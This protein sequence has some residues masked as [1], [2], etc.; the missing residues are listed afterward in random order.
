MAFLQ[1]Y[2]HRFED[3]IRMGTLFA[4]QPEYNINDF[5]NNKLYMDHAT[6]PKM[7]I[8][9]TT[10][11]Q[12]VLI[13]A[14]KLDDNLFEEKIKLL[15]EF[16]AKLRER[17]EM[18]CKPNFPAAHPMFHGCTTEKI[19]CKYEFSSEKIK[20]FC[21]Q[22]FKKLNMF[23]SNKELDDEGPISGELD[24][25]MLLFFNRY[26]YSVLKENLSKS[27]NLPKWQRLFD[28]YHSD[29]DSDICQIPSVIQKFVEEKNLRNIT[30]L[31][32]QLNQQSFDSQ[33]VNATLLPEYEGVLGSMMVPL[34]HGVSLIQSVYSNSDRRKIRKFINKINEKL[35]RNKPLSQKEKRFITLHS[36]TATASAG[37]QTLVDLLKANV[38]KLESLKD[39]E[40]ELKNF[41]SR[42][43]TN[44]AFTALS[45]YSSDFVKF[46]TPK[47][48]KN[49][50][51][52][53]LP[54]GSVV[55]SKA[56]LLSTSKTSD[57]AL[58]FAYGRMLEAVKGETSMNPCYSNGH[59]K[60][61]LTGLLFVTW[62]SLKDIV[63]GLT[64]GTIVDINHAFSKKE[65]VSRIH[66]QQ[67]CTFLD[68]IDSSTILCIIPIVWPNILETT[69][70]W[71][72]EDKEY[73][74]GVFS[75]NQNTKI[76]SNSS[77]VCLFKHLNNELKTPRGSLSG[78]EKLF[79]HSFAN[80]ANG[81]LT[82]KAKEEGKMLVTFQRDHTLIPYKVTWSKTNDE[83]FSSA[84][85][86]LK[87]GKSPDLSKVH[88]WKYL[89][90]VLSESG[91]VESRDQVLDET[92][93]PFHQHL[94]SRFYAHRSQ[95]R[96]K[97]KGLTVFLHF[98]DLLT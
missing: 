50:R 38:E 66:H 88:L 40:N 7:A 75:I 26:I 92:R 28:K 39:I 37:F 15:K 25:K 36:R 62:H 77:P 74:T 53:P 13:V 67:E 93:C 45:S 3:A 64:K 23:Y 94:T 63:E 51:P 33:D 85:C 95:K 79:Y 84:Q 4:S 20:T 6:E 41:I 10:L 29:R 5:L 71:T 16:F 73:L 55:K 18:D 87:G 83:V 9:G 57:H 1:D 58:R 8:G 30:K 76:N 86:D 34:F 91:K 81:V 42:P 72:K 80:I 60:H 97:T 14:A 11:L 98:C 70:N 2:P 49:L 52:G 78:T 17:V 59:P 31:F 44:S 68:S 47:I 19:F 24:K 61:R 96:K 22:K 12:N 65:K 27:E 32:D 48:W 69:A 90:K 21:E 89:C 54:E 56:P 46:P 82:A 43:M 35:I